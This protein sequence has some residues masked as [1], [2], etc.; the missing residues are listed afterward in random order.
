MKER[1]AQKMNTANYLREVLGVKN[2]ICP[3]SLQKIRKL[4][5]E[6]PAKALVIVLESLNQKDKQLLKKIL[7][8]VDFESYSL[9]E[10]K[11]SSFLKDFLLEGLN[12]ASSVFLFGLKKEEFLDQ[13][14]FQT[15][16]SLKELNGSHALQKKKDLW[17][18][19]K[20][21]KKNLEH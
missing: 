18:E 9:L 12:L 8:S 19:L 16:Y 3:P 5:G 13:S 20:V 17:A 10:V 7:S 4:E 1:E 14:L 15:P 2:Y 11:D 21:W 6:L